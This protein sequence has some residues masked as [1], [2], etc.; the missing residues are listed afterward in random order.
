MTHPRV[1][2]VFFCWIINVWM[3]YSS[4]DV[5]QIRRRNYS[6]KMSTEYIL[7]SPGYLVYA[8]NSVTVMCNSSRSPDWVKDKQAIWFSISVCL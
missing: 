8:V 5:R 1:E 3:F 2:M 7:Q 6:S 4:M